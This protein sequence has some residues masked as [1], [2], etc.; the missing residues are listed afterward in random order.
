MAE[1]RH[2]HLWIAHEGYDQCFF[3]AKVKVK[4]KIYDGL[5]D[6]VLKFVEANFHEIFGGLLY[7]E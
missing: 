1:C 7:G 5:Y 2:H 6:F 3:C 4:G